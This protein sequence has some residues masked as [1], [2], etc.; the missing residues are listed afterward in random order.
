MAIITADYFTDPLCSWSW[1]NEPRYRKLREAFG[2]Q[3]RWRHRMGGL[4]KDVKQDFPL[5]QKAG[6]DF[7]SIA[8]HQDEV[9]LKTRMPI[10]TG[11]WRDHPPASTYPAAIAVKGVGLQGFELEDVFLRRVREGFLTDNRPLDST[12]EMEKLAAEIPGIDLGRLRRD[13][14]SGEAE[15]A[16]REDWEACRSPYPEARDVTE[17]EGR[18]RYCFPTLIFYNEAGDRRLLDVDHTHEDHLAALRELAPEIRRAAPPSIETFVKKYRRVATEEVSMACEVSWEEAERSLEKMAKAGQIR[19][20]PVGTFALWE[21]VG[22]WIMVGWAERSEAQ[23]SIR[24]GL[25]MLGFAPLSP[26]YRYGSG[27]DK[28]NAS[29]SNRTFSGIP[30][31]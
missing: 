23:Q 1:G 25:F 14:E 12:S 26:T 22:Y 21:W 28:E 7:E 19:K 3:I 16:F 6:G 27:S 2:D 24:A 5:Y 31:P 18:T 20:R 9:S 11:F 13:I 8:R 15:R 4:M 10:D 30:F 29:P 17:S